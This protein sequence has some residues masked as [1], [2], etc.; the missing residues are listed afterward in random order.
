ASGLLAA[1]QYTV[2]LRSFA[3]SG[4][5]FQDALGTALD[6]TNS[7]VPG[8]NFVFTFSV[9][10]LPVAVGI[11][12]FAR[13]PS[14]TDAIFLPSSIGSAGTFALSY[15]NPAASPTTGTAVITFSTSS[16]ILQSNIQAALNTG[17]LA[18]QVGIGPGGVPNA[19][20]VVV[21]AASS[22]ANVLV[23]FQNA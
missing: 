9:S 14:N 23:T 16:A 21:N 2:T 19:A 13:G 5:G 8:S 10:T 3:A 12:D 22:G 11:P 15:T 18:A 6:G 20:V 4:S 17:G 7:G 1:G